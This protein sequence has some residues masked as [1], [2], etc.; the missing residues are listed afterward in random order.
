MI[1]HIFSVP[2]TG[3]G[4]KNG[5]RGDI[6]LKNRIAVF[7]QFVIPSLMH[8]TKKEFILWCQWRPEEKNNPH[9]QE[10][11]KTLNGLRGLSVIFTFHGICL[12]DDVHAP[13][14]AV[15]RLR[16]SLTYSLP[17]LKEIVGSSK[18]VYL[19]CQPSDDLYMSKA[20]DMIQNQ[21][22]R[23]GKA[24]GWKKGYIMNYTN[25]ELAEYNP[26]TQPPF[27]TIIFPAKTFLHP[28]EHLEYIG[29]Y[30]SHEE[31]PKYLNFKTLPGRGFI[32]GTHGN[33]ISTT[34]NH[35]YQ[36]NPLCGR[37][38]DSVFLDFGIWASDPIH[39]P[40]RKS[41]ILRECIN[42]LPKPIHDTLKLIYRSITR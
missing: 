6:W 13:E 7:K 29:P 12:Y 31:V 21:A 8:Q 1:C 30:K 14:K 42:R 16:T 15:Q 36:G 10:L 5:Y 2:F 3:L 19:T 17:E 40:K 38:K 25:R 23:K 18:W 32:V 39:L 22:P 41:I 27:A 35:P 34:F 20:V 37:T 9:V 11:W 4:R 24:F 26:E 28:I 33:N